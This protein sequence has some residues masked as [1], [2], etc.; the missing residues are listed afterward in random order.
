DLNGIK[1]S[2]LDRAKRGIGPMCWIAHRPV[3]RA[4]PALKILVHAGGGK[5]I[6]AFDFRQ[7]ALDVYAAFPRQSIECVGCRKISAIDERLNRLTNKDR[8][9]AVMFERPAFEDGE[10]R[11]RSFGIDPLAEFHIG[12]CLVAKPPS[13]RTDNDNMRLAAFAR[14]VKAAIGA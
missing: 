4:G 11:Y 7:K 6:E 1:R 10:G 3:M 2:R 14:D 12:A 5:A 13:V 9:P 8:P